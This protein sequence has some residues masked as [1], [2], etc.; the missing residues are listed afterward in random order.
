MYKF[1]LEPVLNHRKAL[2]EGIQRELAAAERLAAQ[3]RK[4][5]AVF[6]ER[7][8]TLLNELHRKQTKGI[9]VSESMIYIDFLK[10][11]SVKIKNQ[12]EL[13]SAY[14]KDVHHKRHKLMQAVKERKCLEKLAEKGLK[15]HIRKALKDEQ[16]FMNEIAVN[17]FVRTA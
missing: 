2:E 8:Q 9:G 7:R 16:N 3:E 5:L 13:V 17:R 12:G 1:G 11:F 6:L 14:E 10:N 4:S 15:A